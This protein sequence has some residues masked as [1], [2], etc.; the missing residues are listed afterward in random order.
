MILFGFSGPEDA[1]PIVRCSGCETSLLVGSDIFQKQFDDITRH[2]KGCETKITRGFQLFYEER[3]SGVICVHC[4][5]R[6]NTPTN[7]GPTTFRFE[8][9]KRVIQNLLDHLALCNLDAARWMK[10]YMHSTQ[11]L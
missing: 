1:N 5:Q 10:F 8:L 2:L 9:N 11:Q 6:L 7:V 3:F 4:G